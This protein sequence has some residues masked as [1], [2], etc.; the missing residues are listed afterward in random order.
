LPADVLASVDEKLDVAVPDCGSHLFDW[1][2][3]LSAHGRAGSGFGPAPITYSEILAWREM[4][5]RHPIHSWEIEML[6]TMDA[7][8][9]TEMAKIA[10][11]ER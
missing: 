11:E 8:Y 9:R 1:F 10:E 6:L 4:V 3:S 7:A 5:R 2:L